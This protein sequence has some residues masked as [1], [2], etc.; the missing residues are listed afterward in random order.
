MEHVSGGF[1][2]LFYVATPIRRSP[3]N[4]RRLANTPRNCSTLHL[5]GF[6]GTQRGSLPSLYAAE[7][8]LVVLLATHPQL[9]K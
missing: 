7:A 4:G 2:L 1:L 9:H 3:L 5:I 6:V 8:L